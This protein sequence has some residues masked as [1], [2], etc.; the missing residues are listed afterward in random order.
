MNN[1]YLI[2]QP[3]KILKVNKDNTFVVSTANG[4]VLVKD[5]FVYP[6]IKTKLEKKVFLNKGGIFNN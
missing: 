5:Y 1:N 2:Q 3:G 4:S 6:E